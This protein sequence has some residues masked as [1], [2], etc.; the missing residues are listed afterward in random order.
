MDRLYDMGVH[1]VMTDRPSVLRA[2]M[3]ARGAW[4]D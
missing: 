2:V 1:A 4:R 3:L